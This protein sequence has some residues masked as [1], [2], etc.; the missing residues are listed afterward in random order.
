MKLTVSLLLFF[1]VLNSFAQENYTF[2]ALLDNYGNKKQYN[3]AV[4]EYFFGKLP[5]E[6]APKSYFGNSIVVQNSD[7]VIFCVNKIIAF[8]GETSYVSF[9]SFSY[10]GKLISQTPEMEIDRGEMNGCMFTTELE[11]QQIKMVKTCST[12][13]AEIDE[14]GGYKYVLDAENEE[15]LYFKFDNSGN[16]IK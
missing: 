13:K 7:F 5:F 16:F 15:T 8:E 4:D 14:N 6:S 1:G 11:N 10:T 2:Q 9:K 12:Y 3:T